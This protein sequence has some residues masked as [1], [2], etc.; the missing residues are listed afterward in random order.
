MA[1]E[2]HVFSEEDHNLSAATDRSTLCLNVRRN[3]RKEITDFLY[4]PLLFVSSGS[5]REDLV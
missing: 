1:E 3:K 2:D 5:E 4:S